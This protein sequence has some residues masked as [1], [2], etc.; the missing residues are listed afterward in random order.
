MIVVISG[1]WGPVQSSVN[2][3]IDCATSS[4]AHYLKLCT[5]CDC[6]NTLLSRFSAM[7]DVLGELSYQYVQF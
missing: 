6:I 4:W 7:S 5:E 2:V 1:V 3:P